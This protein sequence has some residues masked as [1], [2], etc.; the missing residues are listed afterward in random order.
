MDQSYTA[1]K[2][3]FRVPDGLI[4]SRDDVWVEM[5]GN[6]ARIGLTDLSQRTGGDVI[7]VEVEPR[8][9]VLESGNRAASYETIKVTL[10]VLSP[11]SGE[12]V[13][14]NEKLYERPELINEDPYGGGWISIIKIEDLETVK[15]R[16][17]S[18][19]DYF[20]V[21]KAKVDKEMRKIRG[22]TK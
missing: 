11:V 6:L 5:N 18:A 1:D 3:V 19:E 9:T 22:A 20:E 10:D 7:F 14:V 2:F 8:G 16:L 13:E 4:Y 15:Q 21:M 12:V 17:L